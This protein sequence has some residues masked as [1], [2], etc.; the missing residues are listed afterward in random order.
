MCAKHK[1]RIL[2]ICDML[3]YDIVA[4]PLVLNSLGCKPLT[5]MIAHLILLERR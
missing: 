1:S 4:D 5:Y 2:R 3:R